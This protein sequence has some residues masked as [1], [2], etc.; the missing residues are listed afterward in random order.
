MLDLVT[1]QPITLWIVIGFLAVSLLLYCL[2]GGADFGAG[3]LEIFLRKRQRVEQ[4]KII[5]KAMGPVWEANHMWLILMVVIL[6]MG[7]PEVYS[8]ISI[9]LHLPLT[10][11]LI[12]IIARGCSFTFRHYDA[13]KGRSQKS[14][15]VF[16]I[17]SSVWTP[18]CLGI[19]MGSLIP[20]GI[21][22]V[23]ATYREGFIDSWF[24]PFPLA[25]GLFTVCLFTFLAAVFLIGESPAGEIRTSFTRRARV[26]SIVT[27]LAGGVV[28]F[29][30]QL[31]DIIL[32]PRFLHSAIATA[33]MIL[34]TISLPFFW[35]GLRKEWIWTVRSLAGIQ[36]VLILSAWLWIQFPVL[37]HLPGGDLTL[38]NSHAPDR[39]LFQ[40]AA[41]L[42][43]GSA[44]IL[45]SLFYLFQVFK[46][47]EED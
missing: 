23:Y 34:A 47:D 27:V 14:Y 21:H 22:P 36:V 37:V 42:L 41:A 10:A 43:V 13:K 38:F 32:I 19:V 7:F 31:D 18:L 30:A 1:N 39:T 4:H 16:F 35:M 24:R 45:P 28:F 2:L 25:L 44:F 20:G 40:L 15:A 9:H 29:A 6:F 11:M 5:E 12:G 33:C 8:L 3:V 17:F 46:L 26:A